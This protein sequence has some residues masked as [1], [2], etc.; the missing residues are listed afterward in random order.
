MRILDLRPVDG[1]TVAVVAKMAN[2]ERPYREVL[3]MVG[4][5]Q[6]DVM[7]GPDDAARVWL[8]CWWDD[9]GLT[10]GAPYEAA[11]PLEP[12]AAPSEELWQMLEK[13]ADRG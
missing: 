10:A 6:V 12:G 7:T 5:A 3:A 4:W 1:W 13:E 9:L 8:P 11:W 2:V